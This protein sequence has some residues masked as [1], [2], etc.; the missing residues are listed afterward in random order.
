MK[1]NGLTSDSSSSNR[2]SYYKGSSDKEK[3]TWTEGEFNYLNPRNVDL[4]GRRIIEV[5]VPSDVLYQ[6]HKAKVKS[7]RGLERFEQGVV[8]SLDNDSIGFTHFPS[9]VKNFEDDKEVIAVYHQ[10]VQR[11]AMRITGCDFATVNPHIRRDESLDDS[12]VDVKKHT[13]A[14]R[15]HAVVHNDYHD[16]FHEFL[17][18]LTPKKLRYFMN[19]RGDADILHNRVK[20]AKRVVVLNFWRSI[21]DEPLEHCPLAMCARTSTQVSDIIPANLPSY[22]GA[23]LPSEGGKTFLI[24]LAMWNPN[25]EWFYLPRMTKDECLIFKTFDSSMKPDFIPPFHSAFF[26]PLTP[27]NATKRK[28]VEIRAVCFWDGDDYD[29]QS[30]FPLYPMW[31]PLSKN[32]S[33]KSKL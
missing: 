12:D 19:M 20:K 2:S 18:S 23:V 25:H 32:K 27:P 33:S 4:A 29:K 11:M 7:M 8:K 26:D 28:S 16:D 22:G 15:A 14:I 31:D 6:S 13:T 3:D 24:Q 10:E 17:T 9:N 1:G 21:L 5:N 30:P